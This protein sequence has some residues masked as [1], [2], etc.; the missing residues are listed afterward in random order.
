M[1]FSLLQVSW[2]QW[3][4]SSFSQMVEVWTL[5]D[6]VSRNWYVKTY[7]DR[8]CKCQSDISYHQHYDPTPFPVLSQLLLSSFE[9]DLD[10]LSRQLDK[11]P[12]P[13]CLYRM[14]QA[15]T[16]KRLNLYQEAYSV[17]TIGESV[18]EA[19]KDLIVHYWR[20]PMDKTKMPT[21]NQSF[22]LFSMS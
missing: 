2:A 21:Q 5:S 1:T 6:N 22:A 13:F 14:Q 8:R 7:A 17:H 3:K 4:L 16:S 15:N 9:A 18:K 12:I 11:E 20:S 19:R 10:H